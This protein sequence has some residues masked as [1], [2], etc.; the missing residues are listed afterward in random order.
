MGLLRDRS[1]LSRSF[2]QLAPPRPLT[3]T[4]DIP[5]G[6]GKFPVFFAR[7]HRLSMVR[8]DQVG[9]A[10]DQ[11]GIPNRSR[12]LRRRAGTAVRGVLIRPEAPAL[13]LSIPTHLP[14]RNSR[15]PHRAHVGPHSRRTYRPWFVMTMKGPFRT[16]SSLH[17]ATEKP[18]KGALR[19]LERPRGPFYAGRVNASQSLN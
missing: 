17:S 12:E 2:P 14:Q 16:V 1:E 9:G 10:D 4:E 3:F 8:A 15:E 18:R 5:L 11:F 19:H 6:A 13:Q 7:Q